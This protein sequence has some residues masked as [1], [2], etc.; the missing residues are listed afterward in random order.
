[1]CSAGRAQGR[2]LL[3]GQRAMLRLSLGPVQEIVEGLATSGPL[4]AEGHPPSR[5]YASIYFNFYSSCS[6]DF[7]FKN[8]YTV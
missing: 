6:F 7:F 3:G 4:N 8:Y 2:G 1:M 5:V